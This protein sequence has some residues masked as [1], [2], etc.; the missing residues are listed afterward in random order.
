MKKLLKI[1]GAV[2]FCLI[3]T[4]AAAQVGKEEGVSPM[5]L[6]FMGFGAL[7]VVL[8]LFPG[9]ALF[10]VMLKEIFSKVPGKDKVVTEHKGEGKL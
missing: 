8:Q 1:I 6:L 2:T 7:I 3:P 4:L 5:V 9:V 10:A